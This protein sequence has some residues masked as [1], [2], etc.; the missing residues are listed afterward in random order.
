MTSGRVGLG[1][2]ALA[3]LPPELQGAGEDVVIFSGAA[4][5]CQAVNLLPHRLYGFRVVLS[6][7]FG[8]SDPGGL[9]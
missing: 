8:D 2:Q 5:S 9:W 7:G 4:S 6:N 1:T 3:D